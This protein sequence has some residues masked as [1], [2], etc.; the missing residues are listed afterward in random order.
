MVSLTLLQLIQ[1]ATE[2]NTDLDLEVKAN[3]FRDYINENKKV[4]DILVWVWRTFLGKRS[5][6]IIKQVLVLV[7]LANLIGVFTSYY[8][9]RS[10]IDGVVSGNDNLLIVGFAALGTLLI[11]SRI[12]NSAKNILREH[13]FADFGEK[14]NNRIS[15]LFF[16]KSLGIHTSEDN[17]LNESNVRKGH[18]RLIDMVYVAAVDGPDLIAGIGVAYAMLWFINPIVALIMT[19]L[20]IVHLVWSGLV[21]YRLMVEGHPIEKKWR[22]LNRYRGE[23]WKNV[24]RVKS[25]AKET[26]ELEALSRYYNEAIALDLKLWTAVLISWC[27]RGI[28]SIFI[29]IGALIYGVRQIRLGELSPGWIYPMFSLSTQ[30]FDNLWKVSDLERRIHYNLWSVGT[31]KEALSLPTGLNFRE[32][33]VELPRNSPCKIEFDAVSYK[34]GEDDRSS[35]ILNDI[36]F[37]IE[38]EEKVALIGTSGAGKS[39][40]MKLL[41]RYMDP[42]S[43]TIRIDGHDLR[44]I[45]LASWL[46]IVGYIPQQPQ[47]LNGSIRYNALY[48]VPKNK[49]ESI[50]DEYIWEQVRML[51]VDFG[52]RLTD[53][54]DTGIGERGVKL[55][56]GQNQRLM[57]LAAVMKDPGFVVVDEATSSLDSS[58]EKLVQAGLEKA[59]SRNCGALVIAHRLNTVRRCDKFVVIEPVNGSGSKIVGTGRSFEELYETCPRFRKLAEDQEVRI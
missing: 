59:L 21:N 22:H 45:D 58:T 34:F 1:E 54:L 7:L 3:S 44:D 4:K 40:L 33:A 37:T 13:F 49:A 32:N 29:Y 23:R 17:I 27:K 39:T 10:I 6:K 53:G 42:T 5:K 51:Q 52:E 24:E 48:G 35:L 47:V 2:M 31:L 8:A 28:A 16:E 55:S 50:S 18:E 12:V 15:R 36:S 46:A 43:G 20:M 41:L 57:I 11:I 14:M 19:L 25:H 30:V 9:I 38:P 56:G 26:E